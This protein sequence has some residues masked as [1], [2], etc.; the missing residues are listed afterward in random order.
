MTAFFRATRAARRASIV[1][2]ALALAVIAAGCRQVTFE[3]VAKPGEIGIYDDLYAVSAPSAKHVVAVGYWGAVYVSDDGGLTWK[4]GNSGTQKLL[5][6]VSMAD[7]QRGWAVGQE[8]TILRTEDG[9]MTWTPQPNDKVKEGTHLFGVQA[10]DANTAWAVGEWGSRMFTD[11]GGKS[12]QDRSMTITVTHPQFVWLSPPEQDRVRKGG[13]VY[14][15]VGLTDVFCLP[16]TQKCWYIGEFGYVFYSENGGQT[17]ERADI[18]QDIPVPKIV[19]PYNVIDITPEHAEALRAF[20]KRIM[21]YPHLNVAIEPLAS[22]KEI[23]DFGKEKD[24]TPLFEILEARVQSVDAVLQDAGL[25]S[26]RI[27]KRGAPPWDYED[28]LQDDPQF[29][30][31]YLEGRKAPEGGVAVS[32]AQNPYLFTIRFE[33]END[34]YISG[35]GGIVLVS[36]DG[37]HTWTY[38]E[39]GLKQAIFSIYP[40]PGRVVAVGEKGFVRYSQDGGDT[41]A[42]PEKGFPKIFTFMRDIWFAPDQKTGFIVGERGSILRTTDG[43]ANWEEV[44]PPPDH[45]TAAGG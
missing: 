28:F 45:R 40:V 39:T 36:H 15:D 16:N 11:D 8:G 5:Y 14:E 10:L 12:W 1:G 34:G 17:W 2:A 42:P 25:L 7:D 33:N 24:P 19:L 27:R 37:G 21:N 35:L 43:G 4:K 9:G 13:K 18:E 26:D 38:R 3:A 22:E 32:I 41:W 20:A 31:R 30:T 23:T 44:L 6:D 29:L